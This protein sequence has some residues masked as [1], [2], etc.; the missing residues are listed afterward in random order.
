MILQIHPRIYQS[1]GSR[2]GLHGEP[3]TSGEHLL[4]SEQPQRTDA[5]YLN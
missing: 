3:K 4:V 1:A 2:Y 5:S